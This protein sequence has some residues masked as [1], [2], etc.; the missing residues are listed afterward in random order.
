MSGCLRGRYYILASEVLVAKPG[1]HG[2][3]L[4]WE[5]GSVVLILL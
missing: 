4:Q 3:K 2:F 1:F 5:N